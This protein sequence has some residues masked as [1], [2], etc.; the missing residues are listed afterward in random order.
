MVCWLPHWTQFWP[1]PPLSLLWYRP[2]A[3]AASPRPCQARPQGTGASLG[4]SEAELRTQWPIRGQLREVSTRG[5]NTRLIT[6]LV[7]GGGIWI[8]LDDIRK[9][10]CSSLTKCFSPEGSSLHFCQKILSTKLSYVL[11]ML[12]TFQSV[13]RIR[14]WFSSRL[15]TF[16]NSSSLD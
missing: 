4:Q 16:R 5:D 15:Q 10:N 12:K 14:K 3:A 6:S 11:R 13:K 9:E 8:I 2:Q 7:A 1:P